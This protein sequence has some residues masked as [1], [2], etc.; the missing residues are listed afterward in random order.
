M[1]EREFPQ[2][3]GIP[4]RFKEEGVKVSGNQLAKIGDAIIAEHDVQGLLKKGEPYVISDIFIEPDAN[5]RGFTKE[6][7]LEEYPGQ[8]FKPQRFKKAS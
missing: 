4:E 5:Q 7:E 1:T 3:R 6:I 8:R 2:F